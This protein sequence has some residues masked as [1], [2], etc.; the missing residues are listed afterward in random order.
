MPELP[1]RGSTVNPQRQERLVNCDNV[2]LHA[3]KFKRVGLGACGLCARAGS[4]VRCGEEY[5]G[6]HR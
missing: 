2:E 5:L 6:K 4:H 1:G 3:I